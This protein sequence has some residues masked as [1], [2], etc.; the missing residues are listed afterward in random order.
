VREPLEYK[1]LVS[2]TAMFKFAL[3]LFNTFISLIKMS[4]LPSKETP[5]EDYN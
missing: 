4:A 2:D 3:N 5:L 1:F